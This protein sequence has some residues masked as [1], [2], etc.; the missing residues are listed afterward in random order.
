MPGTLAHERACHA[1]HSA[2]LARGREYFHPHPDL[3]AHINEIRDHLN[4][5]LLEFE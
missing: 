3:L 1:I 4:I 2:H 5:P